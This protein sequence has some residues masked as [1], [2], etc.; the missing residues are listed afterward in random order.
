MKK[1]LCI[2]ATSS[3][4]RQLALQIAGQGGELF[5]AGRAEDELRFIT[6]DIRIRYDVNV[7]TGRFDADDFVSHSELFNNTIKALDGLDMVVCSL[8]YLGEQKKGEND[9]TEAFRII[10]I[11]YKAVVSLISLAANYL[12]ERNKGDIIVLS[13]VAGDRGRQSNYIYGSA[14]AGVTV[15]LQGLL[16]RLAGKN[17]HVLTVKLGFVD[18]AMTYGLPGLFGVADPA[19]VATEILKAAI[20]KKNEIY[21]PW[22]WRLIMTIIKSIPEPLFKRLSL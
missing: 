12:E 2:G 22:F 5:L 16:N 21:I 17:V 7:E 3:I 4:A 9:T 15:F 1:V 18:T 19:D 8:G 20:K 11:N 14:K 10:D 13:S 6:E